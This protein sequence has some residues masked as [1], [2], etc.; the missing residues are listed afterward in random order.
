MLWTCW[1]NRCRPK[2]HGAPGFHFEADAPVCPKC[3]VDA[4]SE[5][6]FKYLI[7]P[8]KVIHYDPPHPAVD[9]V[10]M[11]YVLCSKTP[12]FEVT[13]RGGQ[14]SGEPKAVN[15]PQCIADPE[16]PK[17]PIEMD[18]SRVMLLIPKPIP[19]PCKG[20]K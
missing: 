2:A 10:G 5:E 19:A 18:P 12:I 8:R 1:N 20:C 15:C 16:F 3:K 7:T 9:G 6:R 4:R 13:V 17:D 14:V 11:G